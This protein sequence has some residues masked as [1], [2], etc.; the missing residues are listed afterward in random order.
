MTRLILS[1]L[2]VL[3]FS[4]LAQIAIVIPSKTAILTDSVTNYIYILDT[5]HKYITAYNSKGQFFW[6]SHTS[7]SNYL[8]YLN[9]QNGKSDNSKSYYDFDTDT[10]SV[11]IRSMAFGKNTDNFNSVNKGRDEKVIWVSH[12]MCSGYFDLKTGK[13]HLWG[14]D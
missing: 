7:I 14:C 9:F 4:S 6:K 2:L 12:D 5:S 11:K 1:I 10:I 8:P 3:H 13:Y